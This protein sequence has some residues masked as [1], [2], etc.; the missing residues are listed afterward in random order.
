MYLHIIT[1]YV[2]KV[3]NKNT[4]KYYFGFRMSHVKRNISILDD[5]WIKYFT[6]SKEIHK[7]I[8]EY[9]TDA[10]LIE[11]LYT[12]VDFKKCYIKEQQ[13][14]KYHIS[15]ELCVNK[16]YRNIT[17][18]KHIYSRAGDVTPDHI[19]KKIS[20]KLKGIIRS[21][22][23]RKKM[24]NSRKLVPTK[25]QTQEEK[26]KRKETWANR[27]SI[28]KKLSGIKKS[29]TWFNKSE[30]ER[31]VIIAKRVAKRLAYSADKKE[32]IYTRKQKTQRYNKLKS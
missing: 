28:K 16:H 1:P 20:N 30:E 7:L 4:G 32:E 13:L 8:V 25:I 6:S 21:D 18:G 19:K 12:N 24:S 10:F 27:D 9:G 17:D 26:L 15:D 22:E 29:S 2:Y 11:I 5:S 14:I 23:T 31:Q 3:T